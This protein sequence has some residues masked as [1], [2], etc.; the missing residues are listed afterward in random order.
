MT[1][2]RQAAPVV[3]E[4]LAPDPFRQRLLD[5]LADAIATTGYH[6]TTVAEIVRRARTSRRTFYTYFP[7][8]EACFLALLADA[9]A[10][11]VG[12]ISA[13]VD[14]TAPWRDQIRQA[15]AAW[16]AAVE[17]RPAI[18]R[19]WIRDLPSLGAAGYRTQREL[20]EPYI[21]MILALCAT[22]QWRSARF[23]P[24]PRELAVMLLGGLRELTASTVEDGRPLQDIG[25]LAVHACIALLGPAPVGVEPGQT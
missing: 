9:T 21:A 15:V 4:H 24:V 11:V 6:E 22:E 14:P 10:D 25:G 5:A 12:Q 20:M 3:A 7:D 19:S 18:M 23:G 8:K 17:R 1:T 16:L 2:S 13:A